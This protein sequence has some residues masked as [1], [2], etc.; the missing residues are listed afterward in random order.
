M[1]TPPGLR[2][3]ACIGI[4][5]A[6][7]SC[8][9]QS[10]ASTSECQGIATLAMKPVVTEIDGGRCLKLVVGR[11]AELRLTGTYRWNT[12]QFSGNAVEVI[13]IA[14]LRDPGYSAWEVRAMRSGT[15]AISAS[16]TCVA[17]DCATPTLAFSVT[18][19]VP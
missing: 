15:L 14:F 18:I 17:T 4:F 6:V 8:A 19:A 12:P 2:L 9:G 10:G 11:T 3:S 1:N 13:P 16:G 7:A 5:I